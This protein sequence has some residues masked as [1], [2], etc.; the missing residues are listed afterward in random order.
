MKLIKKIN[1]IFE[2][3]VNHL[4]GGLGDDLS[5]QDVD[6]EQLK[7]GIRVEFEHINNELSK[8]ITDDQ[9]EEFLNG[10]SQQF[11]SE[12]LKTIETSMDIA[13]D[14]LAEISDYYT[15][16]AKMESEA[17]NKEENEIN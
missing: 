16:L 12:K 5:I 9:I 4:I 13:M 8:E 14:H 17:E 1:K 11:D 2:E 10:D 15:R 3:H 6:R 7:M